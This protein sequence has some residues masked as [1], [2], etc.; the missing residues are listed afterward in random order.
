MKKHKITTEQLHKYGI[1]WE[2]Y[3][4]IL[5]AQDRN[6]AICSASGGRIGEQLVIDHDHATGKVRGLLCHACNLLLGL[7]NDDIPTFKSSIE[8]LKNP[9]W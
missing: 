1:S 3:Y 7:A 2:D 5:D 6:C 4:S 8:Y 9:T